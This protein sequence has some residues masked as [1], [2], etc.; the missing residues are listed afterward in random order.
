MDCTQCKRH[1]AENEITEDSN[2]LVF[3]EKCFEEFEAE[4][5]CEPRTLS[6]EDGMDVIAENCW[7]ADPD[8]TYEAIGDG[9]F[10]FPNEAAADA[11][12]KMLRDHLMVE[13][14]S[15]KVDRHL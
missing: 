9:S 1:I 13:L 10:L 15:C 14:D 7:M 4:N 6:L 11:A 2:G 3:H 5:A 8:L 12:I